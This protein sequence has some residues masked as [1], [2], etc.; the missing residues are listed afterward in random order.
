MGLQ[1]RVDAAVWTQLAQLSSPGESAPASAGEQGGARK[2]TDRSRA[3]RPSATG[4]RPSLLPTAEQAVFG[5]NVATLRRALDQMQAGDLVNG[6][7]PG[8]TSARLREACTVATWLR[9]N[10]TAATRRE[11]VELGPLLGRLHLL[12]DRHRLLLEAPAPVEPRPVRQPARE[13]RPL[14][15]RKIPLGPESSRWFTD[16]VNSK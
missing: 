5:R 9:A 7:T 10:A 13:L 1:G 11:Q 4:S 16:P 12:L 3:R 15:V 14:D 8:V 6:V 2:A